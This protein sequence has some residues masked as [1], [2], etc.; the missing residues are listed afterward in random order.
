[1]RSHPFF[2][3]GK[4][5]GAL[6]STCTISAPIWSIDEFGELYIVKPTSALDINIS[7]SNVTTQPI[8]K[9]N[10]LKRIDNIV[11]SRETNPSKAAG[12]TTKRFNIYDDVNNNIES[13]PS[14]KLPSQSSVITQSNAFASS[15]AITPMNMLTEKMAGF[16]FEEARGMPPGS[17]T[18]ETTNEVESKLNEVKSTLPSE[19]PSPSP[20]EPSKCNANPDD[21]CELELMRNRLTEC[22]DNFERIQNGGAKVPSPPSS[23][24]EM[25]GATKWISRYVDYTSKYGLGFLLND[26]R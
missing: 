18:K 3:H 21:L 15:G 9:K 13:K 6:P 26:G 7:S 1:M 16:C 2:V 5:P 19:G 10:A 24:N 11:Q 22:L 12:A 8:A 23:E 14:V 25:W 20:S 17:S 4:T